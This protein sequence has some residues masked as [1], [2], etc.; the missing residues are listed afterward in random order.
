MNNDLIFEISKYL[1]KKTGILP[2]DQ[3]YDSEEALKLS[4]KNASA[5]LNKKLISRPSKKELERKN[6]IRKEILNFDYVHS[7]LEKITFRE[8]DRKISPR[9]ANIASKIDFDLKRKM[10]IHRLG[11][12]LNKD[13][14]KKKP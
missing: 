12:D 6:I 9:I 13:R 5:F 4:R 8:N 11:L 7:V 3:A 14:N 2:V 1:E 10:I